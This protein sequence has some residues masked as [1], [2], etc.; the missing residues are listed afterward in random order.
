[1]DTAIASSP[2]LACGGFSTTANAVAGTTDIAAVRRRRRR[3]SRVAMGRIPSE[4][5]CDNMTMMVYGGTKRAEDMLFAAASAAA[6]AVTGAVLAK[7]QEEGHALLWSSSS[8]PNKKI[9]THK[10][11]DPINSVMVNPQQQPSLLPAESGCDH[12]RLMSC[13]TCDELKP[14]DHCQQRGIIC[15]Y[16]GKPS[17]PKAILVSRLPRLM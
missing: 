16:S 15:L 14:C 4:A 8:S 3:R 10:T 17:D 2:S 6:A 5:Y 7:Q 12:C 11:Q 9:R 1:M 13:L